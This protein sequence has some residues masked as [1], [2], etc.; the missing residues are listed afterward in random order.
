MTT[1]KSMTLVESVVES[2]KQ[3]Y[4]HVKLSDKNFLKGHLE[5]DLNCIIFPPMEYENVT[6]TEDRLTLKYS[7]CHIVLRILWRGSLTYNEND[8][9]HE[10]HAVTGWVVDD[11]II[12]DVVMK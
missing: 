1:K 7:D 11:I 2:I 6:E 4:L 8:K 10:N 5:D 12:Q 9:E 3:G